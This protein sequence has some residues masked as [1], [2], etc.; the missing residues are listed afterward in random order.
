MTTKNR[1]K[2]NRFHLRPFWLFY[3]IL[4]CVLI[5]TSVFF[6][7]Y[8]RN[9]LILFEASQP[10]HYM[11]NVL[12]SIHAMSAEELA[13]LIEFP[14]LQGRFNDLEAYRV[15]CA[16]QLLDSDLTWSDGTPLGDSFVYDLSSGGI[17]TA[18]ITIRSV[19]EQVR[20]GLL[21]IPEWSLSKISYVVPNTYAYDIASPSMYRVVVNGQELDE[22]ERTTTTPMP[23]YEYQE[24]YVQ[25]PVMVNYRIE[26]LLKKPVITVY[27]NLGNEVPFEMIGNK[28]EV[29]PV[30]YPSEFPDELN[31]ELNVLEIAKTWSKFLTKD[32]SGSLYGLEKARASFIKGS[33]YWEMA[34]EFATGID[35]TFVSN[36]T[37]NSFTS[38]SVKDYIRYTDDCFSCVV[39]FEKNM[40]LKRGGTRTD[41]FHNRLF[42]VF[43]DDTDD[44]VDNPRW[45]ISD[46]QAITDI[47]D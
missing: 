16:R 36:H 35:I 12:S 10:E 31:S 39:Y 44:G 41:V 6:L 33:D 30:F 3:L 19:S 42:F 45:C 40:T 24:K 29:A 46:M 38:E 26:N 27:N 5:I 43:Y 20:L 47:A 8:V 9:S 34:Y 17:K 7:N 18:K 13:K 25:F 14:E 11:D 1:D 28:V 4:I 15:E 21:S 32:L 23:G 2:K 22:R 37:L